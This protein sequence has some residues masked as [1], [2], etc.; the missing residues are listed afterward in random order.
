MHGDLQSFSLDSQ[1]L[2]SIQVQGELD[3][4]WRNRIGDLQV[5]SYSGQ[6][7]KELAVT[8]LIGEV[9]DQAALAGVLNT[10]H[11]LGLPLLSVTY[12]GQPRENV[13]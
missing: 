11:M 4:D 3:P 6:R 12:L 13:D 2:Y 7:Q 10:V 1:A 5:I 8:T 9:V